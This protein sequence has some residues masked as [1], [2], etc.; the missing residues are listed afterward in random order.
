MNAERLLQHYE[1]IADAPDA[2]ARLRRFILD[3]A[4]RGKLVP[5]DPADEPA[6]ELLKRIAAEKERLVKAGEIRKPK[7][8]APVDKPPF[9]VPH[10]WQW[11]RIRQV[12]SDRGQ[13]VP[14]AAFTY[15]DVSAINKEVGVINEP[16]IVAP[17]EAPSRA[18]KVVMRGDVIYSCVRPYLLNIAVIDK[19][20]VPK[21]IVS[22]AFAVLNGH[23][24]IVPRYIWTVLRS[25]FMVQCVEETQRG[26]AYPAINDADFAVLPFPLP[27]LAEQHRIVAKVDELMVLCDQLEVARTAREATR[28]RLVAASLVRLNSPDPETFR[29][30]ARFALE[31]L[32]AL[33]ARPDQIKQMRQTIL[34]LA[35]RGKL[36]PQ[37]PADV[38]AAELLKRLK[39]RHPTSKRAPDSSEPLALKISNVSPLPVGWVE[40]L[41]DH[42]A[43]KVTDGEHFRPPTT[44][45]GVYFLS[46]KDIR[47]V[48]VSLSN[49]LYVSSE[50]A[51]KA[52]ARCNPE[53]GDILIVSRGATCGRVCVVDV[54]DTFCLL[55][56]VILLKLPKD[57]NNRYV[58]FALRSQTIANALISASGATAQG[59]IYLRD[60]KK[61]SIPL[62]PLTEQH[63]IVA[64][65]DELLALCD[66]LEASLTTADETRRK[67]LDA[68]LG[69]ALAP[70]NAEDLQTAAE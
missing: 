20:F 9:A 17:S 42:L 54:H 70:V 65:V 14:S 18:R 34:N 69:E 16:D 47:E 63:R 11:V 52:R 41:I 61:I 25:P 49:P 12:T 4:V 6:S 22:T 31:A 26:L 1:M 55:G 7:I 2:I 58:A 37:D 28:D 33:T 68:L 57:I 59:A 50:T 19:E 45:S 38:P 64:K 67:L 3:L 27:P 40:A 30:D 21:P 36:V 66:Q 44:E 29:D 35:V 8:L 51:A 62:P 48:G 60:L 32:P 5:Q 39:M 24:Y 10:S 53:Y 13:E 46:A 56:S 43:Q 23:G 15:I